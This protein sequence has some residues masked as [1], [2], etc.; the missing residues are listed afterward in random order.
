MSPISQFS[1]FNDRI[2]TIQDVMNF[3]KNMD[4]P[5]VSNLIRIIFLLKA[6]LVQVPWRNKVHVCARSL[7]L[8]AY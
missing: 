7:P 3:G 1:P 5:I 4:H 2:Y 8:L 6:S